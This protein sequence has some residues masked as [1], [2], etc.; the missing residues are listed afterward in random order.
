[1]FIFITDQEL[2]AHELISHYELWSLSDLKDFLNQL[3][4]L[5]ICICSYLQQVKSY[6]HMT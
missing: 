3:K 2:W 4:L 5:Y 6:V 1:M